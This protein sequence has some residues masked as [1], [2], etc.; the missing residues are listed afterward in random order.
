MPW[1]S[2]CERCAEGRKLFA[3]LMQERFVLPTLS[4]HDDST[5]QPLVEAFAGYCG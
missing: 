3:P 5:V 4:E 2:L 1:P